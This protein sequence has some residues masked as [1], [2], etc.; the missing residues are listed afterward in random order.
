MSLLFGEFYVHEDQD[1]IATKEK[2]LGLHDA[3]R[4]SAP[5]LEGTA[6]I[7]WNHLLKKKRFTL[8]AG[9]D[10]LLFFSQNKLLRLHSGTQGSFIRDSGD[11]SIAGVHFKI[12]IIF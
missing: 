11:L 1:T 3:F 5:I 12:G 6:G 2:Q 4:S 7:R 8:E 9:W 10:Q